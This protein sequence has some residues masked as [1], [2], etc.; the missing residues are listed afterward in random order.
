MNLYNVPQVNERKSKDIN[1]TLFRCI[2]MFPATNNILQ[3]ISTSIMNVENIPP[4][5]VSP[6]EHCYGYE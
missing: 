2:T 3:N 4:N 6:T 1:I 5:V